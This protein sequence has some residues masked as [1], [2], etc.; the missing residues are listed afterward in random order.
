[1]KNTFSLFLIASILLFISC[2]NSTQ[3]QELLEEQTEETTV[4]ESTVDEHSSQYALDWSGSYEGTLPCADCE[5]IETTIT[6]NNDN[7]FTKTE[8][9]TGRNEKAFETSGSFSW[10]ETGS[11][12]TL[13]DNSGTEQQY[14]VVENGLLHLDQNGEIIT[15]DLA[16]NYKLLKK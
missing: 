9:Y 16:D 1:M 13:I 4:V 6:L 5:G 12:I 15:G 3:N 14:K 11:N 10:D 2:N 7:T 8:T